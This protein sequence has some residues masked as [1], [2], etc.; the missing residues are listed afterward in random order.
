MSSKLKLKNNIQSELTIEH[1]DNSPALTVSSVDLSKVNPITTIAVL[2]AMTTTPSTVWVSGY[3]TEGDGAFGSN[4]FRW[5]STSVETDNGGTVI[6]L[7]SVTTGRYELQYSGEVLLD[8]FG[9]DNTGVIDCTSEAQYCVDNYDSVLL[10]NGVYKMNILISGSSK[11]FKGIAQGFYPGD[12]TV[13]IPNVSTSPVVQ[14]GGVNLNAIGC[15]VSDLMFDSQLNGENNYTYLGQAV[16]LYARSPFVV[17][18]CRVEKLFIRGFDI[19]FEIDCDINAGEA[20]NNVI[21]DIES[22]GSKTYGFKVRGVYNTYK[23]LFATQVQKYAFYNDGSQS[24]FDSI[25][26]SG[27]MAFKGAGQQVNNVNIEAID[28]DEDWSSLPA[29]EI[30]GHTSTFNGI[31]IF[32]VPNANHPVGISIFGDSQNLTN[33]VVSGTDVPETAIQLNSGSSGTMQMVTAQSNVY[34]VN[35]TYAQEWDFLGDVSD[36]H[37]V[38]TTVY[39]T[40]TWSPTFTRSTTDDAYTPNV[41]TAT[42]IRHGN[43]VTLNCRVNIA[44]VDTAGSGILYLDNFPFTCRAGSYRYA[45]VMG[46]AEN[47]SVNG[48]Y[49]A[50]STDKAAITFNGSV[51]SG[52]L[53][54]GSNVI[55]ISY[56]VDS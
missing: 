22:Q 48:C 3:H 42:Y 10:G 33:T 20:F 31:G 4:I 23:K 13:L 51:Y 37:T 29:F 24:N 12:G 55:S 19:H 38:P 1:S 6:K 15:T 25:I 2:K 56:E 28:S 49:I 53:G 34:N 39:E 36:V 41:T 11:I 47:M 27:M 14:V 8:W 7:D 54:A 45:G 46:Q 30:N 44:S 9:V 50:G 26:T 43:L 21:E 40:G 52:V 16:L 35:N 5:N 18:H 17:W 32:G